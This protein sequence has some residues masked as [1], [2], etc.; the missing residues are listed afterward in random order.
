MKFKF[1]KTEAPPPPETGPG[2]YNKLDFEL[3]RYPMHWCRVFK[4]I[5]LDPDIPKLKVKDWVIVVF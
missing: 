2:I 1:E 4:R 5:R 3:R